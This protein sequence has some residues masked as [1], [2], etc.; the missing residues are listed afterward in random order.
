MKG[1]LNIK[2]LRMFTWH[3]RKPRGLTFFLIELCIVAVVYVGWVHFTDS[4]ALQICVRT[5]YCIGVF[6]HAPCRL[7]FSNDREHMAKAMY[8]KGAQEDNKGLYINWRRCTPCRYWCAAVKGCIGIRGVPSRGA[9]PP[10]KR[11]RLCIRGIF[12][13][14]KKKKFCG[15]A[16]TLFKIVYAAHATCGDSIVISTA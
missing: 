13:W 6:R 11:M 15:F 16:R 9:S 12:E 7:R 4:V 8:R 2:L 5:V 3:Q 14:T 10:K 1:C